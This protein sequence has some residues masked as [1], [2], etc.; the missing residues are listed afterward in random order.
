MSFTDPAI[1]DIAR[2]IHR[3]C[4]KGRG[5]NESSHLPLARYIVTYFTTTNTE[6][7]ISEAH[8][9]GIKAGSYAMA[10][11]VEKLQAAVNHLQAEHQAAAVA[12]A[13]TRGALAQARKKAAP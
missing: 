1:S 7:R 10:K 5:C 3:Q 8:G 4:P 9:L 2:L 11:T 6:R 13:N 12:L